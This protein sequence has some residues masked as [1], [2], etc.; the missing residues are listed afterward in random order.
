VAGEWHL[1]HGRLFCFPHLRAFY[2]RLG[3]VTRKEAVWV[4]QPGGR[5]SLPAFSMVQAWNG[6]ECPSGEIDIEGLPW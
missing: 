3:W 4:S 1:G 6:E 5:I 2:E